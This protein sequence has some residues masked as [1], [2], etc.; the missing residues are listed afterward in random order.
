M[1]SG[2]KGFI[3]LFL[4]QGVLDSSHGRQQWGQHHS[5]ERGITV[6]HTRGGARHRWHDHLRES[7]YGATGLEQ[8]G[9]QPLSG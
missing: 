4:L 8:G 7:E 5:P 9:P 1:D 3:C 2:M 6:F